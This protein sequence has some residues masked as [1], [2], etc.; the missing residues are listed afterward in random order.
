MARLLHT[1]QAFV[2]SHSCTVA[3]YSACFKLNFT[4]ILLM[5]SCATGWAGNKYKSVTVKC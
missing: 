2:A 4:H 5:K 3:L 1:N